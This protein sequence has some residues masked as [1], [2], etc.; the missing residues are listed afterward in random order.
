MK[1]F[2]AALDALG[3]GPRPDHEQDHIKADALLLECLKANNLTSVADAYQ[4][5]VIRSRWW[6]AA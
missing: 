2:V 6:R 1:D 3:H 4:R 5:L